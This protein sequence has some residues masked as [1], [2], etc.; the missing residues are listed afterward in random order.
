MSI[1]SRFPAEPDPES[2]FANISAQ[3]GRGWPETDH[4]AL[5]NLRIGSAAE[6]DAAL[7]QLF[8]AYFPPLRSYIRQHWPTLRPEDIED[9]TSEFAT[10]CLTG[11]KAHFLVYDPSH[12]GAAARLRTYLCRVFDNFLRNHHRRSQALMRGGNQ[13]FE[14]LDTA[15]PAA[16]QEWSAEVSHGFVGVDMESYDLHW[17]QHIVRIAFNSLETG[18]PAIREALATL[19]PWI[20]A[21]PGDATLK[22]IAQNLGRTHAALRMQLH[23]LRKAWRQA[24][25]AA[26]AETVASPEEIDDELR[27]LA[28]V[29]ARHPLE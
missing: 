25:R 2:E 3:G 20:I 4:S 17:A 7:R 18:S 8:A 9:L 5:R 28:A 23:R 26:V 27:H 10:L 16:H 12:R 21:D 19:R 15:N 29:L 24:V 11:E 13:Q 14:S 22:Q 1:P 6:K